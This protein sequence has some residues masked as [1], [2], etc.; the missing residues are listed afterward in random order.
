MLWI[1][2]TWQKFSSTTQNHQNH[3]VVLRI[4]Q[5]SSES[6]RGLI[7]TANNSQHTQTETDDDDKLRWACSPPPSTH[8]LMWNSGVTLMVTW[9]WNNEQHVSFIFV[10][11]F[12][13]QQYTPHSTFVPTPQLIY[14]TR[15]P[16]AMV[17]TTMWQPDNKQQMLFIIILYSRMLW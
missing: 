7:S 11:Y 2:R 14:L 16:G 9:Q 12:M 10:L 15:N 17:L 8:F 3:S 5:E 6:C 1:L 4:P 13:M